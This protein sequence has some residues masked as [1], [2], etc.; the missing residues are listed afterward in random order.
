M[1]I[2]FRTVRQVFW[3]KIAVMAYTMNSPL[4]STSIAQFPV[5]TGNT[6]TPPT[7]EVKKAGLTILTDSYL[8]SLDKKREPDIISTANFDY[9]NDRNSD[10]SNK[11]S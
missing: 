1:T 6:R 8:S 4:M 11:V 3:I 2:Y 7:P 9:N 5:M 10:L